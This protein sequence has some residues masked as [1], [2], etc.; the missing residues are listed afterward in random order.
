MNF[1]ATDNCSSVEDF[2]FVFTRLVPDATTVDV[3]TCGSDHLPDETTVVGSAGCF[4]SVSVFN[5]T[6]KADVDA[7]TQASVLRKLTRLPLFCFPVDAPF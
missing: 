1:P 6:I 3:E 2:R 7:A 4:A 5:A